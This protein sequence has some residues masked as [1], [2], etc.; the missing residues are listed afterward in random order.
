MYL[1]AALRLTASKSTC[2]AALR[3]WWI[4]PISVATSTLRAPV[5]AA[6]SSMPPVD[7]ILTCS[8]GKWPSPTR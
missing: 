8:S 7:R 4:M 5:R 2:G 3:S 1:Q 6:S